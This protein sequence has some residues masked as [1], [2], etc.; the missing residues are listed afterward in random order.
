MATVFAFGKSVVDFVFRVDRLPDAALK[1]RTNDAGIT[2]GGCAA[3]AAVAI[4]RLGGTARLGARLGDDPLSE[5]NLREL[6]REN[7]NL[8]FVRQE[9]GGRAP[10]SSVAIDPAG[11]RQIV[12]FRGSGLAEDP[13]WLSHAPDSDAFLVDTTWIPGTAQ[14]LDRASRIDRKRIVDG[15]AP[16]PPEV[17]RKASHIAFSRQ[18]LGRADR[19]EKPAGRAP[20]RSGRLF[21][22]DL[23]YRRV[24]RRVSDEPGETGENPGIQRGSQEHACSRRRLAWR[25]RAKACR[26]G[27]RR[28]CHP[29]RE[30][31]RRPKVRV[32]RW[33]RVL[34]VQ[35]RGGTAFA[36]G[37]MIRTAR[38]SLH[39]RLP[40]AC[41]PRFGTAAP[42]AHV[43]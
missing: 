7:V 38:F 33:T 5:L 10:F 11:E 42:E 2:G 26:G 1:Y 6:L 20:R 16:A 24:E 40:R 41:S 17:L 18:G 13:S 35:A 22:V 32:P 21:G 23:R 43:F 19:R 3:N 8:D 12:N 27:K 15:D 34:S 28:R 29:V 9:K 36:T 31:R 25:I 14:V 39:Q 37:R 4:S 30:C